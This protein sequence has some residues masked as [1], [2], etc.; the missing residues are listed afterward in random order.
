MKV[1]R[2]DFIQCLVSSSFDWHNHEQG[3]IIKN[4]IVLKLLKIE[5]LKLEIKIQNDLLHTDISSADEQ[6]RNG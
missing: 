2:L 3:T 1:I 6:Y 4:H 5:N